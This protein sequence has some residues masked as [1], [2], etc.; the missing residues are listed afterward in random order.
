MQVRIALLRLRVSMGIFSRLCDFPTTLSPQYTS[1]P[2]QLFFHSR[3]IATDG[4]H[5]RM[6][7]KGY[8]NQLRGETPTDL[9]MG[10]S[11]PACIQQCWHEHNAD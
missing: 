4:G 11:A 10:V 6:L 7:I 1:L 8:I 5:V 9:R 2:M 3:F